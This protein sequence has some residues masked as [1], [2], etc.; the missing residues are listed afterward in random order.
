MRMEAVRIVRMFRLYASLSLVA[1]ALLAGCAGIPERELEN[2]FKYQR[3]KRNELSAAAPIDSVYRDLAATAEKEHEQGGTAEY[4]SLLELGDDALLARVHLIRSARR[5]IDVQ[6]FIW[7]QDPTSRFIFDELVKAAER[8]VYIRVLI[9]ALNMPGTPEELARMAHAHR[10]LEIALYK[11]LSD[12]AE[13][14]PFGFWDNVLFKTRDMNRRMHNKLLLV[15]GRIGI[16]GGR[17]YEGKYYDRDTE[18]LFRDRDVIVA[19]PAVLDMQD[20]FELFWQDKNSVFVTQLTDVQVGFEKLGRD[21]GAVFADPADAWMFEE[22]DRLA[23][24]RDLSAVRSSIR[25][26]EA[27]Q[28]RFIYDTP[29]KFKGSKERMDFDEWFEAV[30]EGIEE[31][32]VVQTPYL[33]YNRKI[34]NAL[35]AIHEAKPGFRIIASSNSLAAADHLHVYA[36]SFKHRK[37]LYK[38]SGIDIYESKPYPADRVRYIVGY[39][40]LVKQALQE[41]GIENPTEEDLQSQ[42]G[43]RL[44]IHAKSFVAD[45]RLALVGS[46]NFDPRSNKLNTECGVFIMDDEIA[47]VLEAS[48]LNACEPGNAWTVSKAPTVPVIS[49]FSGFLG[50]ISSALPFF[51]VWPYRYTTN[52]ELKEGYK[53]LPPRDPNFQDHYID[54]GYFP[55]VP[56]TATV[57]HTRLMKAFGG[58]ARPLM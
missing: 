20:S 41:Q 54:V 36:L 52:Y 22:I 47:A 34:R 46:H 35:K 6:T 23:D 27:D 48:I 57:I 44:C 25:I 50:A 13:P 8:G 24:S 30:L 21:D 56:D 39:E 12:L 2:A 28:V 58:W 3:L 26:Y 16:A 4:V 49:H 14:G 19:G 11:P 38:Q 10:N 18:F 9:D 7:K 55:E 15:D 53:P 43:P 5:S 51:D 40:E 37:E 33:I 45:H 29:R 42:A 31:S 32:L 17:N 1:A